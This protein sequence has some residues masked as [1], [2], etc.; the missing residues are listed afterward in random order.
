MDAELLELAQLARQFG[1]K[2]LDPRRR[3][4]CDDPQPLQA[5]GRG[6]RPAR[7]DGCESLRL[8]VAGGDNFGDPQTI[9]QIEGQIGATVAVP[10]AA[11]SVVV[12]RPAALRCV[13]N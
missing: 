12:C 10:P 9:G 8:L 13:T 3:F 11:K 7:D 2:I 1:V 4:R 5:R 6:V